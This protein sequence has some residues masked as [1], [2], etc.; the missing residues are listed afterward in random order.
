MGPG[1]PHGPFGGPGPDLRDELMDA[2]YPP[3]MVRHHA[4]ELKLTADQE[5]KLKAAIF[6]TRAQADELAW[7]METESRK[8]AELAKQGTRDQILAQL[9]KVLAIETKIKRS[10]LDLMLQI[11]DLLTADQRKIL[12]KIKETKRAAG[13]PPPGGP[14]YGPPP[15][16]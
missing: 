14:G 1:G 5:K 10:H 6:A 16:R 9:D 3:Q 15:P 8:L 13:G 12:D 7:N 2:L 11:R 4:G